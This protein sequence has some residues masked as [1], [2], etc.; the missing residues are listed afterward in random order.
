[1]KGRKPGTLPADPL[2]LA[3][4]PKAPRHLGPLARLE[5]RTIMPGLVEAGVVRASDLALISAYCA[6]VAVIHEGAEAQGKGTLDAAGFRRMHQATEAARRLAGEF[7]LS[8]VSRL[9]TGMTGGAEEDAG[10][11]PLAV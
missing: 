6:H 2:A 5:W 7:G 9:K 10:D 8:P 3:T 1:M 4:V 11:D